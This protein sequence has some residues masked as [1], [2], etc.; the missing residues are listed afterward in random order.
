[1]NIRE[2]HQFQKVKAQRKAKHT[3]KKLKTLSKLFVVFIVSITLVGYVSYARALPA[4]KAQTSAPTLASQ[5]VA[6]NWPAKGQA[7]V[8]LLGQGVLAATADPK[9]VP[10]A[11]V[12][13]LMMALK[14]LDKHP[15]KP[16]EAGPV[17]T[18]TQTDVNNYNN[19][20]AMG[21][22]VVPVAVGQQISEYQA[23][24]ALLLPSAN[25][26]AQMLATW[27][28]GS[29]DGYL[30]AANAKT[31]DLSMADT[32]FA[33]ASGY[34]PNTV[35]T[36]SDLV[37]LG[38]AALSNP[39]IKQIVGQQSA[40]FPRVGT[41]Y[42]TN[43]L[44]G[45]DG[46]IGIKTGNTDQAG[47]VYLFA[48]EHKL[49]NGKQITAIG[50]V[51][52]ADSLWQAMRASS[53]LLDSL[54]QGFG[55]QTAVR[56]GRKLGKITA[57]WGSSVDVVAADQL[58]VYGWLGLPAKIEVNVKLPNGGKLIAGQK[59]GT[60]TATTAYGQASVPVVATGTIS[61]PSSSWR[62]WRR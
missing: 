55:P 23:L 42:N 6:L 15:L 14:V 11:S 53:P 4:L 26:I 32:H 57:A 31:Q 50:A 2:P 62:L 51:M 39:V 7:A 25:N 61:S 10:T 37:L 8:G 13:K 48:A 35:S 22:S 5:K 44:L 34:S 24:Q 27:S 9:P 1:M 46:N 38:Q 20:L 52:G 18:V 30:A 60:V 41:I 36:P 3:F 59:V 45:Y 54:Y 58:Q 29:L 40:Q 28:F 56:K 47:G 49:A 43:G 12:A 33:D 16:G 19:Y 21:G 17:I